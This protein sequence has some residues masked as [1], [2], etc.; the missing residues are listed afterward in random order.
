MTLPA[1]MAAV[2]SKETAMG[3]KEIAAAVTAAGYTSKSKTFDTIIY[4]A[5]KKNEKQF[6]K[7]SRG[8]YVLAP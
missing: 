7:S 8:R 6:V 3:V 2:M 1:A 5:L 4:Q